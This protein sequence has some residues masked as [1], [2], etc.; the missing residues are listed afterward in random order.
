MADM[1]T[2]S[3][4][5]KNMQAIKSISELES[6]VTKSLWR[7]GYRFRRNTKKLFGSPDISIEKYKVVIFIDSCF[8]HQCP[9]HSTLPKSNIDYWTKKL[10][11]NVKRDEE[12]NE[13]YL[14][15]GWH[16][17]RVWECNIKN[18]L[19]NIIVDLIEFIDAA[20]KRKKRDH[21]RS[22]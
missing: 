9:I 3:Q 17:K 1:M 22:L 2:Q 14:H 16:I 7:K 6:I 12:V 20:K 13:Y 4:R 18:D 15:K 11:R 5:R 8:W 19:E 10:E 21:N